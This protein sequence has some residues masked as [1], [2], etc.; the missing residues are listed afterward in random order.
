MSNRTDLVSRIRLVVITD[1]ELARPRGLERVLREALRAGA[2][3]VQLRAKGATARETLGLAQALLPVVRARG[4]LFFVNDRL[5]VALAAGA[6]G[7]HLG[8]DDPPV[9]AVRQVT[10]EDFLVGYSTHDPEEAARAEADG[11]DYLGCG[12]VY[13]T[14]N[15]PDAGEVIGLSG[16]RRV[17]NAV[18]IPVIAIGG[19]TPERAGDVSGAG[20]AG[21]AVIGAVMS[22]ADPGEAVRGLMRTFGAEVERSA[23]RDRPEVLHPPRLE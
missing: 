11:A 2:P 21:M 12:T 5:D 10:G 16:L 6:D 3:A 8:P 20:A 7:I 17:V 22:A 19:I 14:S 4:A 13:R 1:R 23:S 15:K 18:S 9:K